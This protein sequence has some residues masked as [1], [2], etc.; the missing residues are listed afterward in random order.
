MKKTGNGSKSNTPVRPGVRN[1]S[2]RSVNTQSAEIAPKRVS[3][4]AASSKSNS[5][6]SASSKKAS[7]KKKSGKKAPVFAIAMSAVVILAVAGGVCYKLGIFDKRYEIT[8]ADGTVEK[9]TS[10]ELLAEMSADVFPQGIF[11]NG[12][13]VSLP[14]S[15]RDLWRS[16]SPFPLTELYIP[17]I[18]QVFP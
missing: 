6:S 4:P 14:T 9:L 12:V 11:I 8:N 16:I 18:L 7:P 15:P 3:K 13:D 5:K 17:W 1:T 10:E 2:S